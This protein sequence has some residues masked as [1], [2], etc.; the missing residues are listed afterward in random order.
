MVR[1]V[2]NYY[3]HHHC[4]GDTFIWNNGRN[5]YES[6]FTSYPH[7]AA[8]KLTPD[9]PYAEAYKPLEKQNVF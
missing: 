8:G 9:D 2:D 5:N 7:E 3:A 1:I 6:H 4:G